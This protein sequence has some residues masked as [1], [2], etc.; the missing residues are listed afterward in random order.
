MKALLVRVGADQSDGGGY[1]NGPVD[2]TSGEFVYVPIP[3]DGP[4]HPGLAKPY[5]A[6]AAHLGSKWPSLPLDLARLD[7]HLDPDFAHLTYGDQGERAKQISTKLGNGDLI[8]FYAGLNDIH[9]NPQLVYALIGLYVIDVI[10]PAK[11]VLQPR[12]HENAHTRRVT[13]FAGNDIVVRARPIVSGRLTRA[14]P[15]GSY[16][17]RAYRI[18]PELLAAWGGTTVRNG[19]LQRG[20]R[21]PE[22]NDAARFYDWFQ[23]QNVTLI[24]RNN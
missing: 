3:D 16:R 2:S 14:L 24:P 19:Y 8:V 22:F 9:P 23:K 12:W 4:F 15:I 7:T 1:W 18:L 20:A 6:L 10:V 21:L 5:S 13:S 17:D 11:S